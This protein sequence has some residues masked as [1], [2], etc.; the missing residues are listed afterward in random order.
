MLINDFP[1][2]HREVF[3]HVNS[4][5]SNS[6]HSKITGRLL[7]SLSSINPLDLSQN[8]VVAKN[9]GPLAHKDPDNSHVCKLSRN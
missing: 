8:T 2:S 4:G 6:K 7:Y 9:I 3:I 1:R 5:A